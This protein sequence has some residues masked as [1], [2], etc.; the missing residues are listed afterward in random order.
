MSI[1]SVIMTNLSVIT[2]NGFFQ[3]PASSGL[4]ASLG[5]SGAATAPSGSSEVNDSTER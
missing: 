3:S 4:P 1:L 5:L 2:A